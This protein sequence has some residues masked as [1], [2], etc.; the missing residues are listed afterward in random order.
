MT[1]LYGHTQ[2]W[3]EKIRLLLINIHINMEFK[4]ANETDGNMNFL[5][6]PVVS[7]I[8]LRQTYIYGTSTTIN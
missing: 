4:P 1:I 3:G 2:T 6:F 5:N 7:K 8:T